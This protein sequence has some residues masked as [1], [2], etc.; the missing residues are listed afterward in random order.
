M[1]EVKITTE[2]NEKIAINHYKNN[3]ESVI[4]IAPGWFMTK[5][6][7]LMIYQP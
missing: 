1:I 3:Y 4:I 7:K 6:K 2:D 5:D